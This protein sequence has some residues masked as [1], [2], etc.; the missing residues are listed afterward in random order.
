VINPA[1]NTP[2]E[3]CEA[4][5]AHCDELQPRL[6]G[7]YLLGHTEGLGQTALHPRPRQPNCK[8]LLRRRLCIAPRN[9]L[10]TGSRGRAARYFTGRTY[11]DAVWRP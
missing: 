11:L 3:R 10:I 2:L 4:S 8:L 7:T 6:G 5:T 1:C 9:N